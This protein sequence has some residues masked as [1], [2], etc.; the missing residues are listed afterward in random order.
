VDTD[1][2]VVL[3]CLLAA[4]VAAPI[5]WGIDWTWRGVWSLCERV[6]LLFAVSFFPVWLVKN[7]WDQA[8]KRLLR[9]NAKP[10]FLSLSLTLR[11]TVK[12]L[13]MVLKMVLRGLG[14]YAALLVVYGAGFLVW[15]VAVASLWYPAE[16]GMPPWLAWPVAVVLGII[17]I[18]FVFDL[19][20]F[21][22]KN[23][24]PSRRYM[25]TLSPDGSRREGSELNEQ[26]GEA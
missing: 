2:W 7:A 3:F 25:S 14:R 18:L 26:E 13:L 5:I 10:G 15:I 22:P 4:V 24:G 6:I 8:G 20:P 12:R 17:G 16:R 9:R 21:K 1:G 11:L 19:G 23:E